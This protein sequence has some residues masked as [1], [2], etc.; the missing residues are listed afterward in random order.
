[1]TSEGNVNDTSQTPSND[2]GAGSTTKHG[3]TGKS[4]SYNNKGKSG[5]KFKSLGYFDVSN[6]DFEGDTPDIGCVLGLRS[7]K[8]SRKVQFN[9]FREKLE[10][11]LTKNLTSPMDIMPILKDMKDPY[12]D[13]VRDHLPRDL[14]ANEEKSTAK[15][16]IFKQKIKKYVDR[17]L[18]LHDN[19]IKIYSYVWGQ[20]SGGLRAVISG[21]P[22]YKEKSDRR[23]LLWLLKKLKMAVAGLDEKANKYDIVYTALMIVVTMRQGET[24]S[25]DDYL[26][27]F[28][29]NWETMML[30]GGSHFF[31]SKEIIGHQ[32]YTNEEANK[33]NEA[34]RSMIFIKRSDSKRYGDLKKRLEEANAVKRDE[35]PKTLADAYDLLVRTQ[36]QIRFGM[37]IGKKKIPNKF[38]KD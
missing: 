12:N 25:N 28:K 6:K 10:D 32:F 5:S 34:L 31:V 8:I 15:V 13:F 23:D 26:T 29:S 33:S 18:L 3:E 36:G 30:I 1:M 2:R 19:K 35:Y 38:E 17:E 27:R 24:E 20:C 16:E 22:E 14:T 9:T 21:D 4:G 11:Y 7:E 37:S